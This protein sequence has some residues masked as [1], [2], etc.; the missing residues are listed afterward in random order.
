MGAAALN[1][2]DKPLDRLTLAESAYLGGLPKGPNNYDPSSKNEQAVARRAYVLKRMV[3]NKFITEEEADEASEQPLVAV[4]RLSEDKYVAAAHFVEQVRREVIAQLGDKALKEGGLSIRA[5][6]D[7][8]LQLAAARA[9]R[10]GL[11]QYDR[12]H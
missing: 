2:F 11:E 1:Y 8:N 12:R 9:L 6:L 7:T 3:E 4:N 10:K 5:T